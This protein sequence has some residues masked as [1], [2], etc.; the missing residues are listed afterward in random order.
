M[1]L[2]KITRVALGSNQLP[3]IALN[4]AVEMQLVQ[5]DDKDV[6]KAKLRNTTYQK[7]A[8]YQGN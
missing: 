5:H 8:T 2:C 1:W 4:C 7:Y 3:I 6:T